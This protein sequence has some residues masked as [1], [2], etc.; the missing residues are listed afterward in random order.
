[1]EW[2]W[3]LWL[4]MVIVG[5]LLLILAIVLTL[6][7]NVPSL[8]DELS[9]RKAKRQIKRLKEANI[10]TGALEGMGTDDVYMAASSGSLLSEEI[11]MVSSSPEPQSQ[12]SKKFSPLNLGTKKD[13]TFSVDSD[14]EED[15][16]TTDMEK[17]VYFSEDEAT[18]F[19]DETEAETSYIDDSEATG[20][21]QDIEEFC[22]SRSIIEIVEEQTSL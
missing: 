5:V 13:D 10:G 18:N 22:K 4:T 11:A 6:V 8:L 7:F 14:P 17:G 15:T 9:G 3:S 2:L 20:I 21:L 12:V 16:P 19:M 1:M